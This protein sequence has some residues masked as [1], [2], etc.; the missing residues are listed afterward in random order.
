MWPTA[1]SLNCLF[2]NGLDI[3]QKGGAERR[4]RWK[5]W[6]GQRDAF[7]SFVPCG[8]TLRVRFLWTSGE[9]AAHFPHRSLQTTQNIQVR[10]R[11][12][13]RGNNKIWNKEPTRFV[14]T[15][16]GLFS[17]LFVQSSRKMAHFL[18]S[19]SC[20]KRTWKM[21]LFDANPVLVREVDG[22]TN[23]IQMPRERH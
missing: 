17:R 20:R 6:R 22:V 12:S 5:R 16:V 13:S 1:N 4:A 19:V 23:L 10:Q 8:E 18:C 15:I 3:N 2:S 7:F 11:E 14:M 21:Y 9:D